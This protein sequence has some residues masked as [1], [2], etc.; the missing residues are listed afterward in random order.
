MTM[1]N[2]YDPSWAAPLDHDDNP[3]VV[4][5]RS[6]TA[7]GGGFF[8]YCRLPDGGSVGVSIDQDGSVGSTIVGPRGKQFGGID[9]PVTGNVDA[10]YGSAEGG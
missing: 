7:A 2:E 1:D 3:M 10:A 6:G 9:W 8:F 4:P 5:L